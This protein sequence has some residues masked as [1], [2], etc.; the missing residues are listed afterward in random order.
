MQLQISIVSRVAAGC[1]DHALIRWNSDLL[2]KTSLTAI[3]DFD[4]FTGS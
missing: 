1:F 4:R 3:N 2:H